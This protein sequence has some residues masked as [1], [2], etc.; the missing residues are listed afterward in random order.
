MD[1]AQLST[2]MAMQN[3]SVEVSVAVMKMGKELVEQNG[4]QITN[5]MK[6]MEL[7]INPH[8]GSN[9]DVTL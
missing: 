8:I 9:I 2:A 4:S 3:T 7:S 5:M 6:Q 1:I